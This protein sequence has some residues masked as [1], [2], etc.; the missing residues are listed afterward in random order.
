MSE[1]ALRGREVKQQ[2]AVPGSRHDRLIRIAKVALPAGVGVLIA[3]LAHSFSSRYA[4]PRLPPLMA[5]MVV[6]I[7]G[8]DSSDGFFSGSTRSMPASSFWKSGS[9]VHSGSGRTSNLLAC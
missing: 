6:A 4:S 5:W 7:S 9:S 8:D 2:W 3:F 1:A